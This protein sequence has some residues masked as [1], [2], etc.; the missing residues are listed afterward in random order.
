L[1]VDRALE[2]GYYLIQKGIT[3]KNVLIRGFGPE[4]PIED[5]SSVQGRGKNRRVEITISQPSSEVAANTEENN[6]EQKEN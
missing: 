4:R 6:S 5:N 2:V 1:S 3:E